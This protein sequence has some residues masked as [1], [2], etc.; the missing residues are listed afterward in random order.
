MA[1]ALDAAA[2]PGRGDSW[3]VERLRA[4]YRAVSRLGVH[5]VTLQDIADEAGV[6]A[7][8]LHRDVGGHDELLL[9]TMRWVLHLTAERIRGRV[10]GAA[11]AGSADVI[12]A[13]LEAIWVDPGANRDFILFYLGMVERAARQSDVEDLSE[14][15][16][17]IVHTLYAELILDGVALGDFA[18]A[19][20]RAAAQAMRAWIEGLFIQWLQEENWR[21]THAEYA[22]RCRAGLLRLLVAA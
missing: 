18:V 17:S 5:R 10:A 2:D 15:V 22:A 20:A 12:D 16:A 3:E 19:D 4:C 9:A 1:D 21:E 13:L 11:V 8:L 14:I 6:S 7:T